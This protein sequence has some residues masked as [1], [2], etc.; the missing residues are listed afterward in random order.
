MN[1]IYLELK[2]KDK[3]VLPERGWTT[4]PFNFSGGE[5]VQATMMTQIN[6]DFAVYRVAV[7]GK[8]TANYDMLEMDYISPSGRKLSQVIFLP[9]DAKDI[10]TMTEGLSSSVITQMLVSRQDASS[11]D[12]LEFD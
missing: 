7:E 11:T 4:R 2:W 6:K 5:A 8:G 1:A 9:N 3:F 10:D 12:C